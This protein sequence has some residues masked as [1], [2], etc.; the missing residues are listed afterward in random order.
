MDQKILD[1]VPL[2]TKRHKIDQNS[3]YIPRSILCIYI[4]RYFI[5]MG[6]QLGLINMGGFLARKK[7]IRRMSR[8]NCRF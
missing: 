8:W 1:T 6:Q 2:Q 7:T 5:L 3:K 4:Y